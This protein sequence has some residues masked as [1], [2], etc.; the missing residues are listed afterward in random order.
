[1]GDIPDRSL[2]V[3]R[4]LLEKN[5]SEFP[6]QECIRF[7]DGE[8]WTYRECVEQGYRSANTLSG[9]GV[10]RKENVLVFLPRCENVIRAWMGVN[11]LGAVLIPINIDYRGET[12]KHVCVNSQARHIITSPELA[13]RLQPLGLDIHIVL[14]DSLKEGENQAP[15][16]SEPIE[17]WDINFMIY[18][19]GTTG[20]SKGVLLTYFRLFS[21]CTGLYPERGDVVLN[22]SPFYH[23]SGFSL[24]M[25]AWVVS[26]RVALH[27]FHAGTYWDLTR[28]IGATRVVLMGTCAQYLFSQPPKPD[29]ADNSVKAVWSIPIP[30]DPVAFMKRFGIEKMYSCY[31]MTEIT[32]VIVNSDPVHQPK[33]CG[34]VIPGAQVRLV[35][36][37]D[38]PVPVGTVGE[39]IIR[40]DTPWE[41]NVGYWRQPELTATTWRNGWFH[42]GDLLYC[43]KDGNYFFADRKKDCL[44]RRGENISSVEVEHEILAH[45]HV[46]EVACVAAP[47]EYGED[48]VKIFVVPRDGCSIDPLKLLEFLVPRM[49]R[50]MLPRFIEV[51][52]ELPHTPTMRVKKHELRDK[53]NSSNTWDREKVISV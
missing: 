31:A 4:C 11:F 46:K 13:E 2:V 22:I 6:D 12:L 52:P 43:D 49:P 17:P 27:D 47:G 10:Q 14:A 38:I 37:N 40:T 15:V 26:G 32:S 45:P 51:I 25:T 33:S 5:A 21:N 3:L 20:L 8:R 18:T 23:L 42:T 53:G 35:D 1:M 30:S 39:A 44:R 34:K 48:E 19:S 50:F 9:L 24:C 28:E 41:L 7:Q 29:D 16:L 36:S